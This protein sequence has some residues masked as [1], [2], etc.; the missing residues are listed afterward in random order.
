MR[1]CYKAVQRSPDGLVDAPS[2]SKSGA[3]WPPREW[4]AGQLD[5]FDRAAAADG[6]LPAPAVRRVVPEDVDVCVGQQAT[7]FADVDTARR[8][9]GNCEHRAEGE[10]V[11]ARR[12]AFVDLLA[13][14]HGATELL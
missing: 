6:P 10:V 9:A 13:V 7:V 8:V 4:L 11:A 2:D 5:D 12:G 1:E 14:R 3:V